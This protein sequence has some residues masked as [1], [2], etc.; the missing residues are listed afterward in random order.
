MLS[1]WYTFSKSRTLDSE[2]TY[3]IRVITQETSFGLFE[4]RAVIISFSYNIERINAA[5]SSVHVTFLDEN[6]YVL[7]VLKSNWIYY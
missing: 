6:V 1:Y 4:R 5:V 3:F 2:D 7:V